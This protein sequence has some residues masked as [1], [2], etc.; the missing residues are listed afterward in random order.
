MR[1]SFEVLEH[2]AD[3]GLRLTGP[4]LAAILEQATVGLATIVGV[5]RPGDGEPRALSVHSEDPGALLVDWLDQVLY[6][7]DAEGLALTGV[8]VAE[9]LPDRA[10]GTVHVAPLGDGDIE[11]IQVKA[12]TYH[13]LI[14]ERTEHGW[15]AEV[16]L[17]V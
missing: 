5:W 2:T 13:R 4:D 15:R 10:H 1:G 7:H 9:A 12:I 17:D 16:Y 11:G 14:V 6:L 8:E 3:I